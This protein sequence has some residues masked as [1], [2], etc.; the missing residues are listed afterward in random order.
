MSFLS[1]SRF[2]ASFLFNK[3]TQIPPLL[4][5]TRARKKFGINL[6]HRF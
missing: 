1:C 4:I 5:R 3:L 6:R 2:H